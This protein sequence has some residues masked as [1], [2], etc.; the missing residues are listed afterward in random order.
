M[1]L[2]ASTDSIL[3]PEQG[4]QPIPTEVYGPLP[5]NTFGLILGRGSSALAGLQIIPGVIDN[6]YSGQITLLASALQ[7][8]I[9]IPKGQRIAQLVLLPLNSLNKSHTNCPRADAA[10][11]SSDVYWVQQITP[12][13]PLLTLWLDGKKFEG[14][15]DTGADATVISEKY[16]PSSWPCTVSITH[17]QGIGHS[18]NPKRSSKVLTWIDT[19]GNTGQVQ[20]YILPHI[21]LNLWGRDILSQLKLIMASPNEVVTQQMLNQGFLPGLG[22]GK[23]NQ[24]ITRP[25]SLA[26]NINRQGLGSSPFS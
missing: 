10:F 14:L 25:I 26:S 22:L 3:V 11:G 1:D 17:L 5:P 19:E 12:E 20:P 8:P 21:P 15:V 16:W 13:R 24:G 18:T 2:C 9:S 7:G 23:N 4:V 6:D